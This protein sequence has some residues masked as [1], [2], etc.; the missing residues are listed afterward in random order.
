M[1]PL[2]TGNILPKRK[3]QAEK[4]YERCKAEYDKERAKLN[5]LYDQ[6]KAARKEAFQYMKNR[7]DVKAAFF[8]IY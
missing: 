4:E 5:E 2:A 3:K 7:C 6:Q 8:W 1:I